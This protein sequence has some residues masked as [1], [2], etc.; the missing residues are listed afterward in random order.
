MN[1][2][3]L[4]KGTDPG[5]ERRRLNSGNNEHHS[6]NIKNRHNALWDQRVGLHSKRCNAAYHP[7]NTIP[8]GTHGD[9]SIILHAGFS[10]AGTG[11]VDMRQ[12]QISI[13]F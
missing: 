8:M 12:L 2:A 3:V 7:K 10:S 5:N 6:D 1:G 13:Y 9:G 4:F 11:E